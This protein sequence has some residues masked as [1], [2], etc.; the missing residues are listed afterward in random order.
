M[1]EIPDLSHVTDLTVEVSSPACHAFG[2]SVANLLARCINLR[3]LRVDIVDA[4]EFRRKPPCLR[5]HWHCACDAPASWKDERIALPQLR[6]AAFVGF[7]ACYHLA[8]LLLAGAPGLEAMTVAASDRELALLKKRWRQRMRLERILESRLPRSR[9][10]WAASCG[11]AAA[12]AP[13]YQWAP[14]RAGGR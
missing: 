13:V 2:A 9:G 3:R 11:R 7:A 14:P 6:E 12:G 10:R 1:A 8:P 4:M 5:E